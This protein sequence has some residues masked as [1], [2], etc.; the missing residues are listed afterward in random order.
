[1]RL[2]QFL[3]SIWDRNLK[4]SLSCP[5]Y[6]TPSHLRAHKSSDTT[7]TNNPDNFNSDQI[8]RLTNNGAGAGKTGPGPGAGAEQRASLYERINQFQCNS[9]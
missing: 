4:R 3:A 5:P 2:S 1:M 6:P 9:N 8:K 7:A